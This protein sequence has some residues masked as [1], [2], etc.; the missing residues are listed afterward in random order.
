LGLVAG[1]LLGLLTALMRH[2][3][4]DTINSSEDVEIVTGLQVFAA[5]PEFKKGKKAFLQLTEEPKGGFSE[6]MRSVRTGLLLTDLSH[7]R[8]KI[9]VTSSIPQEGKTTIS[10]NLAMALGQVERV[11][12]VDCDLRRATAQKVLGLPEKS[13]GLTEFLAGAASLEQCIYRFEDGKIDVLPVGQIPPN[14]GEILSS[15]QFRQLIE[16]LA[17][18][19]DRVVFDS[20]PCQAVSDTLLLV[21]IADAVLFVVKAD[22]TARSLV[23]HSVR[24]L[25]YARAPVIGAVINAVDMK[26]Y[27]KRYGGYYYGYQYNA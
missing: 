27:S 2:M 8:K 9:V 22:A 14:P 11:L 6:G 3:L 26:R 12:L 16:T 5:L 17:A 24:Q 10:C 20:A 1:F 13:P 19:Y 21:Q 4:S 15:V 18:Q 23:K 7:K 25:R